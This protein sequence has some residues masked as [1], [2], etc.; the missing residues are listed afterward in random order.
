M[1]EQQDDVHERRMAN[2]SAGAG[3]AFGIGLTLLMFL[4]A[5]GSG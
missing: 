1:D 5:T 4:V 3:I 2:R